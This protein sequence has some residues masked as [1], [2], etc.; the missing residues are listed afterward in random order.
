MRA[1]GDTAVEE[2]SGSCRSCGIGQELVDAV[3][4]TCAG[5]ALYAEALPGQA[6]FFT[7]YSLVAPH[8]PIVHSRPATAPGLVTPAQSDGA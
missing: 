2:T 6:P 8:A 1:W 7:R 4:G 5:T 3:N